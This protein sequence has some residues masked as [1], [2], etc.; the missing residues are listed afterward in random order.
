MTKA[1]IEKMLGEGYMM[2]QYRGAIETTW[3]ASLPETLGARLPAPLGRWRP[4]VAD[5]LV[6]GGYAAALLAATGLLQRR[7]DRP[8]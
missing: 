4:A 1:R 7:Y 6:L 2:F 3:T 8:R 5:V